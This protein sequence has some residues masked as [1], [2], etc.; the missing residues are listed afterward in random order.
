MRIRPVP[1]LISFVAASAV[2]VAAVAF[3]A[4]ILPAFR[5]VSLNGGPAMIGVW[6]AIAVGVGTALL[7]A[8]HRSSDRNGEGPRAERRASGPNNSLER[9]RDR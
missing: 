9:S 1:L 3:G 5:R 7:L 2:V 8:M 6:V 4:T